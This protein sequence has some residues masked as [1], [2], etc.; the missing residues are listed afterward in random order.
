M[1]SIIVLSS[2]AA[3]IAFAAPAQAEEFT[4]TGT[5][6]AVS[7]DNI[8]VPD[9]ATCTLNGTRANGNVVVGT[10]ATLDATS[11]KI[12]GNV[13]AEGAAFVRVVGN[14]SVGGSVQIVQGGRATV[15]RAIINGSLQMES[16]N[17]QLKASNNQI[18]ADL[19]AFQNNGG[20]TLRNNRIDGNLQCKENS[21]APV[22][23]GNRADSK[24]DQCARL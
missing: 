2:L 15:Q 18:G 13:Q 11:I 12:N 21:P 20:V 6:G 1:K 9:G 14:S 17:G 7:L 19:Q 5:L 16:N 3:A 10:G 8:F 23:G 22:G 24:E 4:C